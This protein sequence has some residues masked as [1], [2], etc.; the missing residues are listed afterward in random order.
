[1]SC[2]SVRRRAGAS[3]ARVFRCSPAARSSAA[4]FS[5]VPIAALAAA[6]QAFTRRSCRVRTPG[7]YSAD[8]I[9]RIAA[10][11]S[12]PREWPSKAPAAARSRHSRNRVRFGVR[13]VGAFRTPRIGPPPQRLPRTGAAGIGR[14]GSLHG[15]R[16]G[17]LAAWHRPGYSSVMPRSRTSVTHTARSAWSIAVNSAGPPDRG[18]TPMSRIRLRIPSCPMAWRSS[19]ERRST[20]GSGVR[21]GATKPC[22]A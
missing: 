7:R 1:M 11:P 8:P 10:I 18:S 4:R 16:P 22:Q 12:G 13:L 6:P 2:P 9:R 5:A 14:Q 19:A 20:T 15:Q 17:S 3:G 21:A